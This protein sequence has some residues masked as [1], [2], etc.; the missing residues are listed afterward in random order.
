[1]DG[2]R[3]RI[4][5]AVGDDAGPVEIRRAFRA[6]V[7]VTHPD[8]GGNGEA[9]AEVVEALDRL[10]RLGALAPP[11]AP[12]V[13]VAVA[14]RDGI[15]PRFDS[16]DAPRRLAPIRTFADVLQTAIARLV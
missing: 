5:L 10:D 1:M 4:V 3:A 15:E 6:R 2:R 13:T 7:L 8:H 9:F 14:P 12:G 16:Y 11:H